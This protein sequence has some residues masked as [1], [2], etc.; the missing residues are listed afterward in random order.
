MKV[1]LS[2]YACE[3]GSGSEP[4]VGWN[5]AIELSRHDHEIWVLTRLNN[6]PAIEDF[7]SFS[8]V[9]QPLNLHFLYYDLPLWAHW[10]KKGNRGVYLY[11]LLW[12]FGAYQVAKRAHAKEK[13]DRVHHVTFVSVRQPSF[14]GNLGIPFIFGPVAGGERAPWRLRIGYGFRGLLLD[15]IRDLLNLF[16]KIDP[17]MWQTFRQATKIYVTSN[18]TKQLIPERFLDKT[19]VQLA[20]GF[21]KEDYTQV[22]NGGKKQELRIIYVGRFLFWKGMDLGFSAFRRLLEQVPEARLTLVGRGRE[23]KR[24]RLYAEKFGIADRV[25]WITWV[26]RGD[27]PSLFAKHDI[28]LFP[29]LHD[30][31]GMVVLEAMA[32][33]LPVVCLGLGG[34]GVM[35]NDSCGR[36]IPVQGLS[37]K[38]VVNLLASALVEFSNDKNLLRDLSNAAIQRSRYYNWEKVIGRIIE[39]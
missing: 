10:W 9:I 26:P 33:G 18:Q 35:V 38:Q 8:R 31:G 14:M 32:Q 3:P 13:F 7:F 39:T 16:V 34:P 15:V 37:R 25:D 36:V 11:Y 12:Q 20:I 24:W 22:A 6:Q 29:S 30:S 19:T 17:L 21:D 4:G 23:E 27:M 28:L 1:L 5:W 2:A